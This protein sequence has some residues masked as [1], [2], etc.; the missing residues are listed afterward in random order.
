[1]GKGDTPEVIDLFF[2]RQRAG[3]A[4]LPDVG[5]ARLEK[6]SATIPD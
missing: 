3:F 6:Y 2:S 4:A 5:A 1:M